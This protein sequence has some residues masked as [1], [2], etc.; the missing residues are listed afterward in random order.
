MPDPALRHRW[1]AER[2]A[3]RAEL[4][5]QRD[6]LRERIDAIERPFRERTQKVKTAVDSQNRALTEAMKPFFRKPAGAVTGTPGQLNF[7]MS[8]AFGGVEWRDADN[9]QIA[10]AHVRMRPESE[11]K[12]SHRKNLL[13]GTYPIQSL[14]RDTIWVWAGNF[15]VTFATS[16]EAMKSEEAVQ[17]AVGEFVD[18]AALASV[19]VSDG[20]SIAEAETDAPE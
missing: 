1:V 11:I 3:L 20:P 15:L 16:H 5:A 14:G 9:T 7:T 2:T 10:W 6:S 17:A 4:E 19:N 12:P 13:H 18:L 8:M